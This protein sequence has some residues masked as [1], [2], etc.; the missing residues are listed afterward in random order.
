M[1]GHENK[2]STNQNN[3]KFNVEKLQYRLDKIVFMAQSSL[4]PDSGKIRANNTIQTFKNHSV[5]LRIL[6]LLKFFFQNSFLT[7]LN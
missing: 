4:E 1:T 2:Y 6:G 5:V 7:Y 3:V